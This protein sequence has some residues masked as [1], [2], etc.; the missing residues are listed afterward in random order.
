ML[1][2]KH[3]NVVRALLWDARNDYRDLA[4]SLDVDP[5]FVSATTQTNREDVVKCFDA[6]LMEV[7]KKGVMQED[8]A[9]ALESKMVGHGQLAQSVREA[10]FSP[11]KKDNIDKLCMSVIQLMLLIAKSCKI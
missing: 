8:L 9:I 5:V 1:G 6:V 7:L 4:A 3:F 2:I 10:T 11:S